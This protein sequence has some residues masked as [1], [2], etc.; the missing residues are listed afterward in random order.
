MFELLTLWVAIA[1]IVI[2]IIS[3]LL[4]GIPSWVCPLFLLPVVSYLSTEQIILFWIISVLGSQ[5]FGT[6]ASIIFGIPGENSTLVFNHYTSNFSS[7]TKTQLIRQCADTSFVS[8]IISMCLV[9]VGQPVYLFLLPYFG[10]TVVVFLILCLASLVVIFYNR[11]WL[12]NAVLFISGTL[13]VAKSNIALPEFFIRAGSY[14]YDISIVSFIIALI[15]VPKLVYD[16]KQQNSKIEHYEMENTQVKSS[17]L[18]GSLIGVISGF[19]PGPTATISSILAF[20]FSGGNLISRIIAATSAD[21]SVIL[22]GA[23]LFLYLQIP[24]AIDAVV[25]NSLLTQKN[26]DIVEF[27]ELSNLVPLFFILF[28]ALTV[29]W[30]LARQ[31]NKVY[32]IIC[33]LDDKKWFI[34]LIIAGMLYL[35]YLISGGSYSIFYPV[36]LCTLSILG[37]LL[38]RSKINS[39]PLIVGFILGDII[40]WT[41]YQTL[42]NIL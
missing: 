12:I 16:N 18:K 23:F 8:T 28:I 34:V 25:V 5:F 14:T 36:W 9:L 30:L 13:M 6:I 10:K 4:P 3:G 38:E 15:L 35:D 29:L 22:V 39:M 1:A 2:A 42:Q 33:S 26:F 41:T 32:S 20:R 37:I 17:T 7:E 21:H 31:T 11:N 27:S 19:L 24:L 40:T